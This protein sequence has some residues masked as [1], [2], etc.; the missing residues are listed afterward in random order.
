MVARV[1]QSRPKDLN[2]FFLSVL[3]CGP[4]SPLEPS[5]LGCFASISTECFAMHTHPTSKV[6]GEAAGQMHSKLKKPG[7]ILIEEVD[8]LQVSPR[9]YVSSSVLKVANKMYHV[10]RGLIHR[11]GRS[12]WCTNRPRRCIV[13][14][15][16]CFEVY[17]SY[18]PRW[19]LC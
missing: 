16:L 6:E 13:V 3:Q 19:Q 10:S 1:Q 17:N 9:M 18:I 12:S 8:T 7:R 11:L 2:Q 15:L 14:V 4:A 5:V